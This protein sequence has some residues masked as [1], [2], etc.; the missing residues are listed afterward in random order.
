VLK[1]T[2][3][4]SVR[5]F[6]NNKKGGL[7]MARR[8]EHTLEKI[9][10]MV[11]D[12]AELIVAEEGFSA[13]KV[14]RIAMEIGYTVGSVYMVFENMT[15]L[16]VHIKAKTL[17]DLSAHLEQATAKSSAELSIVDLA[18]AYLLFANTHFN[19]WSMV[20]E[21]RLPQ[22][23]VV[24][25]WYQQKVDANFVRIE[26]LLS[27]LIPDDAPQQAAAKALWSGV[28]G[29][30]ILSL[31]EALQAKDLAEV[32]ANVVLL[33]ESFIRGWQQR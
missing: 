23:I 30:C 3:K 8:S 5:Q 16:I 17:D 20:F 12:A 1:E 19:R 4:I 18:K 27:Q 21:Y 31:T 25:E 2:L 14:R 32:E 15:D 11:M 26:R 22:D 33:V 28:H 6:F 9:R 29:I 24:P 7:S 13:L 10:Q